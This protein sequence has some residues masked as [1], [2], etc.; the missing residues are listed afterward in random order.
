MGKCML[1]ERSLDIESD[2][3]SG[4]CGGDCWGCVGKIEADE[5]WEQSVKHVQREIDEGL[6]FA[7]GRPKP[8]PSN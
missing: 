7:D 8:A 6:R 5:G 4:D 2:P 1:C 3:M